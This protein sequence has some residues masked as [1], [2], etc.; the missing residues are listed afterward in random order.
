MHKFPSFSPLHYPMLTLHS[1]IYV[2]ICVYILAHYVCML[3]RRSVHETGTQLCRHSP[4]NISTAT[5]MHPSGMNALSIVGAARLWYACTHTPHAA[6]RQYESP[7]DNRII[8]KYTRVRDGVTAEAGTRSAKCTRDEKQKETT[9]RRARALRSSPAARREMQSV[10]VWTH[11]LSL[12]GG[13]ANVRNA[14]K[15][16]ARDAHGRVG[17]QEAEPESRRDGERAG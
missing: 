4:E 12:G 17:R 1:P 15:G 16:S 5:V 8:H 6:E 9:R 14:A 13:R 11:T 2:R 3:Q 10:N 7:S